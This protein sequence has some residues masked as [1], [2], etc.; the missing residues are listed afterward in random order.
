[1]KRQLI[2]I[3]ASTIAF[4]TFAQNWPQ[5]RG[6]TDNLVADPGNYPVKFD[7][8]EDLL[9]KAPFP[10]KGSSTPIVWGDRI[11]ITCGVGQ[12]DE[13]LD[14]AL[15]YDFTGKKMWQTTFGKQRKGKHSRGSGSCPSPVTNGKQ[16]FVYYKS[17]TL[18]ALG[19]DGRIL[20]QCN[21]QE[22]YGKDTLWW[23]LGTSPVLV[24]DTVV[25]AVMHEGDSYVV[26]LKQSD[27]TE[28]WRVDRNFDCPKE[29][30]QSYTT[31]L[32]FKENNTTTLV[33]FGADHLTGHD[34]S[35][36]KQLWQCGGFNP[37]QKEYWRV[38]ASPVISGN[39]AVV[40]YGREKFIAGIKLGGNGDITEKARVWEKSEI[41]A[42]ATTP[43]AR[44][45]KVYFVNYRGKMWCLDAQ[46]GNEHWNTKLP[47]GKGMYYSSPVLADDKLYI[48]RE[49]G[50][51]YVYQVSPK[52]Q[53]LIHQTQFNDDFFVATPVLVRDKLIMRGEKHL[54]CIG[55]K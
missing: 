34:P 46:T 33:I 16:I 26:A 53:K 29:S 31:P 47:E 54:Y 3:L 11:V 41:S 38:I 14:G 36:G 2:Q 12:G 20:W 45:G 27:G 40:P 55:A 43:V 35:T 21:I 22:R 49:K 44:D 48:C 9:W 24:D 32:L 8:E 50:T 39:I 23:D 19:F 25:I 1:M 17:G 52:E 42:D 5:W 13:G 4:L 37:N 28:L 10:G 30:H 15:C 51:F 6:P 7:A 18:A